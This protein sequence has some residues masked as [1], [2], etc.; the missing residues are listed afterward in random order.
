[1]NTLRIDVRFGEAARVGSTAAMGAERKAQMGR[2][3]PVIVAVVVGGLEVLNIIGDKMGL[4]DGGGFGAPS[5][6]STI[7]SA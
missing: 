1:V 7:I 3:R 6:R 4:T 5:D 2:K